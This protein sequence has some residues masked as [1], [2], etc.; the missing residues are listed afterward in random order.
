[1]CFRIKSF[2]E[3]GGILIIKMMSYIAHNVLINYR[4]AVY[5]KW[6]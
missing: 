1:M 2:N 5:Y 3:S 4:K 6:L